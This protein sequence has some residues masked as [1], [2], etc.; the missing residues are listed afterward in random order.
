MLLTPR[1]DEPSFL[2]LDL[3][4]DVPLDLPVGDPGVPLLRQ[5]R[6]LASLLGGL[7]DEQWAAASRCEAWTV[8][9][10]IAHLVTTNQFW[11]ASI[12][13][14]L[15]G[16]PT[17]FLAT[18]DPV[19]TADQ[20]VDAVRSQSSAEVLDRFVETNE[21][22]ADIVA[23]LDDEGWSTLG[24]A[25]PG[26]V[27]LRAVALHAL[28]DSWVHERDIVLPL[29]LVP[30]EEPDEII[31]CL[32]YGAALSPAFSVAGGSTREGAIEVDA[33][34]PDVRFVVEVGRSVVVRGADAPDGALR[35]TGSAVELLEALSF[36]RPLPCPVADQH[37]WLLAGL[38]EV[39]DRDP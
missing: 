38:A 33:T 19:V 21:A 28:W 23:G 36:R 1:Y 32:G 37:R 14:A 17:R 22:I 31:G 34:D 26:H 7:D 13:A 12:G 8:Q 29:G 9:D 25:P 2:V 10:V 15:R 24:E 18:F 39:F 5:R 4:L 27:P 3:P 6:R 16:Q 35:L 11:A 20:L 30:V